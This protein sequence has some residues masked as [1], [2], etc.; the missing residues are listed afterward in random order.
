MRRTDELAKSFLVERG[1]DGVAVITFD[2]P[3]EAVN[4]IVRRR[5]ARVRRAALGARPATPRSR[6]RCFISGKPDTFIA[7]ADLRMLQAAATAQ[8]A[9]RLS[10]EGQA[11]SPGSS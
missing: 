8:D 6:R 3:G 2:V 5:P 4:T 11:A 7:G 9:E 10:R 1:S